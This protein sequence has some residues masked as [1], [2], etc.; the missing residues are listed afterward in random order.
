MADEI[1]RPRT[2]RF[3]EGT[4][5]STTSIHPPPSDLLVELGIDGLIDRANME[6]SAPA[7]HQR[8]TRLPVPP[9][10]STAAPTSQSAFSRFSRAVT[11]FWHGTGF[12]GLG[13]R[14]ASE[15]SEEDKRKDDRKRAAEK[16]YEEAKE[17][18]LLPAPKVFTRP[19]ARARKSATGPNPSASPTLRHTPSKKDLHKQAKLSKKVSD[20]ELQLAKAKHQLSLALGDE[21]PAVPVVPALPPTPASSSHFFAPQETS[22]H[23]HTES[24]TSVPKKIVKK[25]KAS[26]SEN[27]DYKP[28]STAS[29]SDYESDHASKKTKTSTST[30]AKTRSTKTGPKKPRKPTR[31]TKKKSNVTTEGVV[32]VVPDGVSV[33]PLPSI[34][35]GVEGKR[36]AVSRNKDDGYGGLEHEMF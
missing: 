5:N 29:D 32:V 24:S 13:K 15:M 25:R 6:S 31:L 3:T 26:E 12:A 2:S 20:L 11:S 7:V 23:V 8:A 14:K 17:H 16:A 28:I 19:I 4:M 1:P 22:P 27:S 10:Q 34:P 21:V 30:A 35:N 9:T 18:G 36:V 33:P